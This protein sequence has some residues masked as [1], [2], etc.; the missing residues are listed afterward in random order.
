MAKNS[1]QQD[2]LPPWEKLS[3]NEKLLFTKSIISIR[4]WKF[5]FFAASSLFFVI[6][7]VFN[8][9]NTDRS[10]ARQLEWAKSQKSSEDS[11]A[12][13][14]LLMANLQDL[15]SQLVAAKIEVE[16]LKTRII[17]LE[18]EQTKIKKERDDLETKIK[19]GS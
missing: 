9:W 12:L 1:E 17:G 11:M 5:L 3:E 13:S 10:Q 2:Q 15:S 19:H 18:F 16:A 6:Q 4:K 8:S 14:K 7:P